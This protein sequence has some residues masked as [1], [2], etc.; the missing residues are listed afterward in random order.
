MS[1]QT[2]ADW[3][4]L[5]VYYNSQIFHSLEDF[6]AAWKDGSLKRSKKPIAPKDDSDWSTR[7][8]KG[9]KRDLDNIAGPRSVSVRMG[10]TA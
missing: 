2:E 9:K 5:K 4:I 1:G 10:P 8:R 7:S 3:K 6:V